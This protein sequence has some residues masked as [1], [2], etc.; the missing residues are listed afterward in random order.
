[1]ML[2]RR[3][4]DV[5]EAVVENL[6]TATIEATEMMR[7]SIRTG[8]TARRQPRTRYDLSNTIKTNNTLI[9]VSARAKIRNCRPTITICRID[10]ER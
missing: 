8:R 7:R 10:S 1:M 5:V 9:G 2:S 4:R 6:S 3:N